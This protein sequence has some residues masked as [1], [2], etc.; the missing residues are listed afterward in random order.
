MRF[1]ICFLILFFLFQDMFMP[2]AFA[3]AN[4]AYQNESLWDYGLALSY[5]K[6]EHYPGSKDFSWVT[7]P[8]PVIEYRGKVSRLNQNDGARAFLIKDDFW[9]LDL[10]GGL[11]PG[12]NFAT[13]SA[14]DGMPQL[15]WV[16]EVG[17]Q[18]VGVFNDNWQIRLGI[19]QA[20][21]TDFN[22]YRTNGQ[23]YDARVVYQNS[24]PMPGLPNIV[25]S[26]YVAL[27]LQGASEDFMALY[28]DV[29]TE[30]AKP[31]RPAYSSKH[32][33]VCSEISVYET[34]KSRMNTF[35]LGAYLDRYDIN[36]NRGSPLL[37]SEQNFTFFI[38]W[39]YTFKSSPKPSVKPEETE[40]I[41]NRVYKKK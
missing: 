34:F 6:I 37:Q 35:Y 4:Y 15:P 10:S 16:L 13:D 12:Q 11:L 29:P 38:A 5:L 40:G 28:Y 41:I 24:E 25:R 27:S 8:V 3:E 22:Y 33:I 17:P 14:R 7:A 23:Y 20:A 19:F 26:D 2:T 31:N 9:N 21:A 36:S 30:F 18:L 1:F 39:G 32:G